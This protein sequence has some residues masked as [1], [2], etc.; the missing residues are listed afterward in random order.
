[1]LGEVIKKYR[2]LKKMTQPEL[3]LLL[4][5]HQTHVSKIEQ[6]QRCPSFAILLNIQKILG[7]PTE[8]LMRGCPEKETF[9]VPA[10]MASPA[11]HTND[12]PEERLFDIML[13]LGEDQ[14]KKVLDYAEEQ[15][16][17]QKSRSGG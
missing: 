11:S 12:A 14:R 8:E 1:M 6:D 5:V 2:K 17:L 4:N 9:D 7:I 15:L 13:M 10:R 3:A 16:E